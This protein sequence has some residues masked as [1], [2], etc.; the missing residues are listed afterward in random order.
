MSALLQPCAESTSQRSSPGQPYDGNGADS[1]VACLPQLA[2]PHEVR[3]KLARTMRSEQ[4]RRYHER[5]KLL[6]D[7]PEERSV[8]VASG[9]EQSTALAPAE[10]KTK[11]R[12]KTGRRVAFGAK[13]LLLDAARKADSNEGIVLWGT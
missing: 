10:T 8:D 3:L 11:R 13:E 12:S 5:E 9:E 6:E 4:L 1:S 2:L 7:S